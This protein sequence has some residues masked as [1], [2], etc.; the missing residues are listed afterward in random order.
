MKINNLKSLFYTFSLLLTVLTGCSD[1]SEKNSKKNES[2]SSSMQTAP[3]QKIEVVKNENA[4]EIKVAQKEYDENQSKSYYYDYNAKS[5]H[6]SHGLNSKPANDDVSAKSNQRTT[7]EANLHV[8]SPYEQVQVSMVMKKL[9]KNF[10][11]KCSACHN[12]YGNGVI[13]P[14]LLGKDSDYI[15]NK[16]AKFK[17]GTSKNVLMSGLIDRM[18]DKEIRELANEIFEFN[19][20]IKEARK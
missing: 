11:V 12:D 1:N 4:Q 5:E 7:L 13:G 17:D 18:D 6:D 8:R 2:A 15:F 10:I 3:T 20:I 14:S 16:I 9:S 19:K